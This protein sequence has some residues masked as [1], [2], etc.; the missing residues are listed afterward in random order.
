MK[1]HLIPTFRG[2][3]EGEGGIRRIVEA[4]RRY[5]P[6]H[7]FEFV[8]AIGQ[9]DLVA[10]HA[11]AIPPIGVNLPWI[12]HTHGLYWSDYDWPKWCHELNRQVITAARRADAMTAPSEWVAQVFRRGMW[13]NPTVLYSGVD[14]DE[15]KPVKNPQDY[16]L[17]NKTRL[18][19]V[20]NPQ[21]VNRLASILPS[22]RFISTFGD[23][24]PNM[25]VIGRQ[26][27]ETAREF[28]RMAGVYLCTTRETFGIGTLEAMAAGV[29]VVGFRWGGQ[30]EIIEHGVTGWLVTPDDYEGLVEG[31]EWAFSNRKTIGEAAR[32]AVLSRFTWP[33]VIPEYVSLYKDIANRVSQ[34]RPKV[35]VIVPCY[36][37]GR[38]LP[39]TLRSLKAQTMKD[40]EAIIV[41]DASIDDTP[42]IGKE[43]AKADGRIK[44]HRNAQNLYLAGAL[45]EGMS[46]AS[47]QYLMALDADNMLERTALA[48]LSQALDDDREIAIAYGACKFVLEDGKTSDQSVAPDG[49]SQWPPDFQFR[50]QIQHRNQIPSTCLMRRKVWERTGGYRRR[51]RTAEDAE[52]WTRA[53]SLGF[54]AR[55]VTNRTTLIYRQREG[56]MSRIESDWDWTAWLPWSRFSAMTPFGVADNPPNRINDG[57][58]WNVPSYEPAKVSVIIPVGPGHE[59]LVIDALDSLA[60]QTFQEWEAIVINDTGS[61]LPIP[62]VW[63]KVINTE[64]GLGPARARNLGIKASKARAFVP[65]DADDY[66]QPD[67]LKLMVET[68][69]QWGG[70]VYSQWFDDKG[71]EQDVYDPP[72]YDPTFLI[73]KGAIHAVT[74]LYPKALW[75]A[76]GGFD[77]SLTHWEDWDFQ[78]EAA[79][80]GV[81]GTKIPAPLFTYRKLTGQR[82]EANMKAFNEG[83]DET[84]AKWQAR[85]I[86]AEK[87]AMACSGCPGG[88]GGSNKSLPTPQSNPNASVA[89]QVN[90]NYVRMRYLGRQEGNRTY[91]GKVTGTKY[92]FG[93]NEGHRIKYVFK[94]DMDGLMN[95]TEHGAP[96]FEVIAA[97]RPADSPQSPRIEARTPAIAAAPSGRAAL[98]ALA[99]STVLETPFIQARPPVREDGARVT[100]LAEG[101]IERQPASIVNPQPAPAAANSSADVNLSISALKEKFSELSLEDMAL[102]LTKER[103]GKNR[104][105]FIEL[106]TTAIKEKATS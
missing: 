48:D 104:K 5:M 76:V 83:R 74:A 17:W 34:P 23:E 43:F 41:D 69:Q 36:N 51:C 33:K 21:P 61:P 13:L 8:N 38:F 65:L 29:P 11:G 67:A 88:G 79:M 96:L 27:Y 46:R 40:W 35:S 89:G 19:P 94:T 93:N 87:I 77:E 99:N 15:W 58:A 66:L 80:R 12:V 4:Q 101:G 91:L 56:S 55:K 24:R 31:I 70:V 52:M 64:G 103:A 44:Y 50:E 68:W 86:T 85:G 2:K 26:P 9:A 105:G 100:R 78:I 73:T 97:P 49:I 42:S 53:T 47:G 25:K 57:L 102:M 72:E 7:G 10:S 18:D 60:A 30:R 32:E 39:D 54:Q 82:R 98:N 16:I 92:R 71:N 63:A 14:A 81:C 6:E 45:N 1:V 90:A 106:L 84:L 59:Q 75:E 20:C 95:L 28:V 22:R 3:D 37:L 62:H